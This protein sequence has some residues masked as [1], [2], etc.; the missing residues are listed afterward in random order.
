MWRLTELSLL[1]QVSTHSNTKRTADECRIKW[2][3]DRHPQI[4]HGDW[5][6]SELEQLRDLV[7]TQLDEAGRVDWVD[8]AKKLGVRSSSHL[9]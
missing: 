4:N 2:S 8:V 1:I 3:G 6:A 7:S 9:F 5:A